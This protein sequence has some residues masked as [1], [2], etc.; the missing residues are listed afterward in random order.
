MSEAS[1][2]LRDIEAAGRQ[3]PELR[4][5]RLRARVK[6]HENDEAYWAVSDAVGPLLDAAQGLVELA[7]GSADAAESL[8][9]IFEA[10]SALLDGL[11]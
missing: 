8:D 5:Q 1:E 3:T 4:L 7:K 6:R 9:G 2:R 11:E 10:L